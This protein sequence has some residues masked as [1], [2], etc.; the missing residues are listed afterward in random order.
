MGATAVGG[1]D[2]DA[3]LDSL[4][5]AA[6]ILVAL[7]V[8]TAG[9]ADP[10]VTA[11]Q[12][13][14]LVVLSGADPVTMTDLAGALGVHPSNATRLCDRLVSMDLVRRRGNA[15]NRR[16]LCVELTERGR[17]LLDILMATRRAALAEVWA[18]LPELR[19]ARLAQDL[20]AFVRAARTTLPDADL[21]ELGWTSPEPD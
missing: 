16:V 2:F 8:R 9:S 7:S 18:A 19:R 14:T 20:D 13:R 3:E 10:A 5:K 15:A 17:R 12:L 11:V 21:A 1:A 6:R 4:M